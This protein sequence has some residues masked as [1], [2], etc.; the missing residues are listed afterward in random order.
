VIASTV[1]TLFLIPA[2]FAVIQRKTSTASPSLDPD[3]PQSGH[4]D[5]ASVS[6]LVE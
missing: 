3:D 5:R 1:A 4:S 6:L 2:I